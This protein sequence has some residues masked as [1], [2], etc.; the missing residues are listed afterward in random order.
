[1]KSAPI[2]PK[3]PKKSKLNSPPKTARRI[4]YPDQ[5]CKPP[6]IATI[7]NQP[8]T[9][10]TRMKTEIE[11][12]QSRQS[13]IE[14][15]EKLADQYQ[16]ALDEAEELKKEREYLESQVVS[17]N[18]QHKR[19]SQLLDEVQYEKRKKASQ[20]IRPTAS[21]SPKFRANTQD[22]FRLKY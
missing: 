8:I 10:P 22:D 2:S 6:F 13:L 12:E 15:Y 20:K 18:L 11:I 4:R 16:C 14:Q 1:M 19:L 5:S 9:S 17:V 7:S 21:E 3:Y